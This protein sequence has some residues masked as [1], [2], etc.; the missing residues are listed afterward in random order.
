MVEEA[1]PNVQR[2][3]TPDPALPPELEQVHLNAAGIDVGSRSH[4]VAVPLGRDPQPVREFGGFTADLNRLA[5]WLSACGVETVAMESTGVYWIPL[6][7]TLD[8]RGFE[9]K[10]VDPRQLKR[11]PGRK[12][13]VLDCQWLQQLHTF[14]LLSGAFR[15]DDQVCVLR[16]YLRQRGSLVHS[17][18]RQVQHMQKALMQMNVQLHHAVE[19]ITGQ[20]GMRILKAILEGERDPSKLAALR[21]YRCKH[22]AATIA[23]ALEGTWRQEHV[24]ALGQAVDLYATYQEKIAACDAR[25]QATI[26]TFEDRSGGAE[27]PPRSKEKSR[28]RRALAP[29]SDLH[30]QLFRMAGVDLTSL[31]GVQPL[32]ALQIVSE[33]GVDMSPWPTEKHFASWLG[34]CPGSKK[35]GGKVLSSRTTSNASRAA[36]AFRMAAQSLH[37]SRTALGAYY[38]RMRARLGG[39][40][41]I[42]ATAHKLARI[43]Y[44]LLKH[45]HAYVDPGQDAYER[46]YRHRALRNLR[47]RARELGFDIAPVTNTLPDAPSA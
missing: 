6:F 32:T 35:S 19:D 39:P 5:H 26:E 4:F 27:P 28:K 42:T 15:P 29:A 17:A 30:T 16:S 13:D 33:T 43:F 3:K 45:G 36:A 22:D 9:V 24:F 21:D 23:K 37:R 18:A 7:E 34:L 47:R 41:A 12:T 46:D 11:A 1:M 25:I 38:R 31:D 2:S 40:Q 8:R 10:L 14:G 44:A 20:T